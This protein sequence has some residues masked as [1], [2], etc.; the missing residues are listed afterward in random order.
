MWL[1]LMEAIRVLRVRWAWWRA[2][3]SATAA[4]NAQAMRRD[5]TYNPRAYRSRRP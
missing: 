1:P 2:K 5:A 3:H 4:R